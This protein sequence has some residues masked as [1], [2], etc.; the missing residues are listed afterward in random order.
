MQ[1]N[2][3]MNVVC[4]ILIIESLFK[5][6]LYLQFV[7]LFLSL[8]LLTFYLEINIEWLDFNVCLLLKAILSHNVNSI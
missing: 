7:V 5:D 6:N 4:V 3:E 2:L 1:L 8:F